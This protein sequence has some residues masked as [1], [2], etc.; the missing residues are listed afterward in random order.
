M[1]SPWNYWHEI[2]IHLHNTISGWTLIEIISIRI[3]HLQ[4]TIPGWVCKEEKTKEKVENENEAFIENKFY[5]GMTWEKSD[6]C[7]HGKHTDRQIQYTTTYEWRNES[8]DE[9]FVANVGVLVGMWIAMAMEENN[10]F[11]FRDLTAFSL[12]ICVEEKM[13][14]A[15]GIPRSLA[16]LINSENDPH[17]QWK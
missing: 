5:S 12:E 17:D 4:M 6:K 2:H 1:V 15:I 3:T 9:Q 11:F 13:Y 7:K 16:F 8:N 14:T 10:S